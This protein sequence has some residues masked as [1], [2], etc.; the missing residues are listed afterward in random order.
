MYTE[1][2]EGRCNNR[3]LDQPAADE[4]FNP[5]LFVKTRG[6][7]PAEARFCKFRPVP[8]RLE[9]PRPALSF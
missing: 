1:S 5:R 9:P 4:L 7:A 6:A 3:K 8:V 2:L